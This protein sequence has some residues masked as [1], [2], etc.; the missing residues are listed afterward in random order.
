VPSLIADSESQ[1]AHLRFIALFNAIMPG[2]T[3]CPREER[4]RQKSWAG[5]GGTTGPLRTSEAVPDGDTISLLA[6]RMEGF[7]GRRPSP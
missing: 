1:A 6:R 7:G 5:G 4:C 2:I 3:D